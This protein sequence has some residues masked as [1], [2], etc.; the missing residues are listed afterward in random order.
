MVSW[1]T[2]TSSLWWPR[3]VA[4]SCVTT[5]TCT[6]A[7]HYW[8]SWVSATASS[9][10]HNPWPA[11]Q[12]RV[13]FQSAPRV[14]HV[15]SP[16]EREQAR[17]HQEEAVRRQKE[18]EAALRK[19]AERAEALLCGN[20]TKA[21]IEQLTRSGKFLVETKSGRIYEIRRGQQH[22]V[23]LLGPDGQPIEEF[24]AHPSGGLPD[25]D[26]MLA[27]KLV[28]ETDEE[29]FCR[30]ANRWDRRN[31]RRAPIVRTA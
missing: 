17:L 1:T 16:E 6:N 18:R 21:Q 2:N 22:N 25:A 10:N 4:N 19:I 28:L 9:C 5:G 7:S 30:I 8:Q 29:H 13:S 11:W 24:C 12:A 23:F 14:Q 15:S 27:Q 26:A 20:L 3:W 31:G